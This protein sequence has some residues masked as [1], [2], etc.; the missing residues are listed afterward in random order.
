MLMLLKREKIKGNSKLRYHKI[1]A[2]HLVVIAFNA[3]I[4]DPRCRATL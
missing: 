4:Y 1:C 2:Y 3:V